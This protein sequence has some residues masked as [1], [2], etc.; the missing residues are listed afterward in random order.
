M[1]IDVDALANTIPNLTPVL[2]KMG[3]DVKTLEA[4]LKKRAVAGIGASVKGGD[5]QARW[6]D[7]RIQLKKEGQILWTN[8]AECPATLRAHGFPLIPKLIAKLGER[9]KEV[10]DSLGIPAP[11]TGPT[12]P[13]KRVFPPTPKPP[14]LRRPA[15]RTDHDSKLRTDDEPPF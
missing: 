4:A 13:K 6:E 2:D 1:K 10:A 15:V 9:V 3:E 8:F 11:P 14:V 7:G 5:F 12:V